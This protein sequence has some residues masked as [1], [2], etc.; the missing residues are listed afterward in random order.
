MGAAIADAM[1]GPVECQHYKRIARY[2]PDFQEHLSYNMPPATFM[3]LKPGY[4]LD[5][6][7]GSI[8]DDTFIRMYLAHYV[9]ENNPQYSASS[10]A[11]WLM[12]N[13]DFSNWWGQAVKHS[14]AWLMTP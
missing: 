13:A 6:A 9:L 12:E 1:G 4:A 3:E 14:N 8:I 5:E 7:P 2:F 11:A 10:F